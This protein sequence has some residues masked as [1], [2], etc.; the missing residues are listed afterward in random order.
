MNPYSTATGAEPRRTDMLATLRQRVWQA[1]LALPANG[2]TLWTSGN[3]SGRDPESGLIVIK[4]SGVPY[5][6][7][8]PESL[9]VVDANGVVVEG[10]ERPS[11]DTAAH[12]YIYRNRPDVG[13]VVHTHSPYAT[14]FALR[15]EPLPIY[16]TTAA[17]VFGASIPVT[18]FATIGDDEI[19]R[20]VVGRIGTSTAILVRRH[21]VFTIGSSPMAALKSAVVLEESAQVAHLA[22]LR[23]N[24]SPLPDDVVE[25]GYRVYRETY[26]QTPAGR[27]AVVE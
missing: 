20:E 17:A 16:S 9:V 19:G 14:S 26:G 18:E 12:C 5:E 27:A 10:S 1:N 24:L 11:V 4:P 25:R 7:L 15:G 2:L 6:D 13:G 8:T 3:A 23:G 22:L 21:G